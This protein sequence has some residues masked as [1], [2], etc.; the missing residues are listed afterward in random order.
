[1]KQL[2]DKQAA[3]KELKTWLKPGDTL[4]TILRHVSGSGMTRH[5]S[6][7]IFKGNIPY[8]MDY[9]VTQA[10]GLKRVPMRKGEGVIIHGA[11]MDMGFEIVYSLGRVLFPKGFK[12][13]GVKTRARNGD[14]SGFDTD[15]GYALKQEWL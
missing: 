11:G 15:G 9:L 12:V 14:T 6:V 7:Y 13:D 10:L 5:I 4:H 3:I 8:L 1:M 2:T